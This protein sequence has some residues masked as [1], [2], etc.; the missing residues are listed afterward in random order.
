MD[1][2]NC[3]II[4]ATTAC[5][6]LDFINSYPL[7]LKLYLFFSCELCPLFYKSSMYKKFDLSQHVHMTEVLL[8]LI[9]KFIIRNNKL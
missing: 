6:I 9:T 2:H 3:F 5:I 8:Y 7:S 4:G 1:K